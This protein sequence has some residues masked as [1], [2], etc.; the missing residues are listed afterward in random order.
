M[1]PVTLGYEFW[2]EVYDS[3]CEA[4]GVKYPAENRDALLWAIRV[5][6]VKADSDDRLA[7]LEFDYLQFQ[8][9]RMYRSVMQAIDQAEK[10]KAE[11]DKFIQRIRKQFLETPL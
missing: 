6:K 5:G 7:E 9:Q 11:L 10:Q 3:Y 1:P 4:H 2:L 8:R